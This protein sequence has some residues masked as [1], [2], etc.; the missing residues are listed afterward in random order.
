MHLLLDNWRAKLISLILALI[1][2]TAFKEK[3]DPGTFDAI[4]HDP[5]A[6]AK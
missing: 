5:S 4:L 2:W 6:Q 3:V 1:V